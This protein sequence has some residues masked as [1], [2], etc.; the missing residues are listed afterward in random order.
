[1]KIIRKSTTRLQLREHLIGIWMLGG[2]LALLGLFLFISSEPP[3]DFAGGGCIAI[4]NVMI[5]CSPVE[6]CSFDKTCNQVTLRQQHWFSQRF[7]L[8][9]IDKIQEVQVEKSAIVGIKFYRVGL[10]LA[11]GQRLYLTQFPTTDRAIQ[12]QLAHQV[13][14]FLKS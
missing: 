8:E 14:Q 3:I 6:T 7:H 10:V 12:Q 2:F 5:L 13:R 9:T 11:S 1:M 4:A